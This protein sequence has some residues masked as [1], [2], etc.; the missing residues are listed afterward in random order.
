MLKRIVILLSALMFMFNYA[1]AGLDDKECKE[2]FELYIVCY[3][4]GEE[5]DSLD[6][7]KEMADVMYDELI[8][9]AKS[10]IDEGITSAISEL[11]D[12]ACREAV[13]D[14]EDSDY[15][16]FKEDECE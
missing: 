13:D 6:K 1:Y 9:D 12:E 10:S 16:E 11:C 15:K 5:L 4:K 2:L 14:I 3:K 8:K 7:C